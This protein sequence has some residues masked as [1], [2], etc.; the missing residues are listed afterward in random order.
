MLLV[1]QDAHVNAPVL[2]VETEAAKI[3][4]E[5]AD[6]LVSNSLGEIVIHAESAAQ[7]LSVHR[8]VSGHGPEEIERGE[9]GK[10][11][12]L[13][14]RLWQRGRLVDEEIGQGHAQR[15]PVEVRGHAGV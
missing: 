11:C 10:R 9:L 6:E 4:A 5:L 7:A 13:G 2:E 8:P 12:D 3:I 15:P 14:E 1:P